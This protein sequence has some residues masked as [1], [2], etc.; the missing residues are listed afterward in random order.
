MKFKGYRRP[1][2]RAGIRNHI[3]ILP[4]SLCASETAR[5]IASQ[6]PGAV[7]IP[8]QGGCA[9]AA[10]DLEIT[11][12]VLSGF[13]ANPNV[14]GTV[15]VGNTCENV[16][17]SLLCERIKELTNKPL[18]SVVIRDV[19]G[20]IKAAEIGVKYAMEMSMEASKCEKE[21]IDMSE[22]VFATECG[23]SDPTSGLA[24]NPTLGYVSDKMV[25]LGAIS[26]LSETSE[27]VGTEDILAPRCVNNKVSEKLL[28]IIKDNEDYFTLHGESLRDGNPSVGNKQGGL[29][30]LE[31]KSLG[32]IHKCGTSTIMEVYGYGEQIDRNKKGLVVMDTPGQDIASVAAMVAGGAQ[33]VVFTTGRGTPTGNGIVPVIKMTGN[34][35]TFGL[36]KDNIDFDASAIIDGKAGIE[37]TGEKLFELVTEVINGKKSK[38]EALGFN[39]MSLARKC[40]FC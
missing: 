16:Q 23:G 39:D 30:T 34:S 37:D 33:I 26:I 9:M 17:A 2:G 27:L 32:C 8:N 14:F 5:F 36:M 6:V 24:A 28:K 11:L 15:V 25:S 13:A 29:T 40:N 38:A 10:A 22:I 31:E 20:T 18:K 4:C 3:L 1:D 35:E 7:Y 21:D 12:K 19:G